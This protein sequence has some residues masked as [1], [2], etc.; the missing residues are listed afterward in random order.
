MTGAARL[1]LSGLGPVAAALANPATAE[2]LASGAAPAVSYW[3]VAAA[4]LLCLLLALAA[5]LALKARLSGSIVGP[6][7]LRLRAFRSPTRLIGNFL[8][9]P[10]PR[11]LAAME[12]IRISPHADV[13]LFRC[14]G[15]TYLVAATPHGVTVL[16]AADDPAAGERND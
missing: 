2:P 10:L 16:D 7:G 6:S 12:T 4:L 13:C 1:M 3:R 8:K 14:D 9:P 5:A 15:K 11:R